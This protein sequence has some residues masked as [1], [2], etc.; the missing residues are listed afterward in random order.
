MNYMKFLKNNLGVTLLEVTISVALIGGTALML[1]QQQQT[2]SKMQSK[3]NYNHDLNSVANIIQT[4][5][6]K[7]SNCT[8]TLLG[9]ANKTIVDGK[10][11]PTPID[12]GIKIVDPQD[13]TK[14]KTL[15]HPM[16]D[17]IVDNPLDL[18]KL[19]ISEMTLE[20]FDPSITSGLDVLRVKF[21][22][23]RVDHLGRF[24]ASDHRE[25]MGSGE[26]TKSFLIKGKKDSNGRYIHCYSE[27]ASYIESACQTQGGKWDDEEFECKM[28][29]LPQC[30]Y[31]AGT[32]GTLYQERVGEG[33]T[34]SSFGGQRTCAEFY[35]P[36]TICHYSYDHIEMCT[37]NY[38]GCTCRTPKKNC[39]KEIPKGCWDSA[40][41]T[42]YLKKCCRPLDKSEIPETPASGNDDEDPFDDLPGNNKKFVP[43]DEEPG[44]AR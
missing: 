8:A 42:T 5:L 38:P 14:I 43:A 37:C 31:T 17:G 24:V 41:K 2:A 12:E 33:K 15:F 10:E 13:P 20:P 34:I 16:A 19:N 28:T 35:E 23:G 32:C 36:R 6:A 9:K 26:I 40:N 27:T 39:F 11:T 21:K 25:M 29:Q 22:A 1:M 18:P 4:E 44:V 3:M 7:R 30:I